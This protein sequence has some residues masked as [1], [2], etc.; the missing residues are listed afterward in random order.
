MIAATITAI[1]EMTPTA[2][3]TITAVSSSLSVK[4]PESIITDV[5]EFA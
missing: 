1:A 3:G 2:M 4:P 5:M